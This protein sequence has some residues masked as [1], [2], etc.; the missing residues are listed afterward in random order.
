MPYLYTCEVHN[1][2]NI[3][4]WVETNLSNIQ[5]HLYGHPHKPLP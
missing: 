3:Y 1:L 4:G 5:Q 2:D